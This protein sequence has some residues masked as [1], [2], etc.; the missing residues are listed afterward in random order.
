MVTPPPYH[1]PRVVF[2]GGLRSSN[3]LVIGA[4]V[5]NILGV[6]DRIRHL[7]HYDQ[8]GIPPRGVL[9][10]PTTFLQVGP[11]PPIFSDKCPVGTPYRAP[12]SCIF[13]QMPCRHLL[14]RTAIFGQGKLG[15][16]LSG[17]FC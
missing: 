1:P 4:L 6:G 12:T 16:T 5:A 15:R 2:C 8:R 17:P 14:A 11:P 13:R 7:Y 10:A 3:G 9:E